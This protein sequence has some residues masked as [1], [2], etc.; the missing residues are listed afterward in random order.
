MS[1]RVH[2]SQAVD[3]NGRLWLDLVDMGEVWF[4]YEVNSVRGHGGTGTAQ[5]VLWAL[6]K[7]RLFKEIDVFIDTVSGDLDS[8]RICEE[9]LARRERGQETIGHVE[10]EAFSIGLSYIAVCTR[11]I[12]RPDSEFLLHGEQSIEGKRDSAGH[13]LEDHYAADWLSRFTNLSYDEWLNTVEG[14]RNLRFGAEQ[15]KEWGVIDEIEAVV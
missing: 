4:P 9:L 8:F 2:K 15:A 10:G 6:R 1:W 3:L 11:R 7:L 14:D 13:Y 12:C 5:T